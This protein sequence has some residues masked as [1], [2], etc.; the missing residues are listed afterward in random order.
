[1]WAPPEPPQH[2][3][4][5]RPAVLPWLLGPLGD[6]ALPLRLG[7]GLMS[8]S[9]SRRVT[10][11][12]A[13]QR[14]CYNVRVFIRRSCRHVF[15]PPPYGTRSSVPAP[16][17]RQA[18]TSEWAVTER[19]ASGT[20]VHTTQNETP[21]R[22]SVA[23]VHLTRW[24]RSER[25]GSAGFGVLRATCGV[26]GAPSHLLSALVRL[27]FFHCIRGALRTGSD[28]VISG[29]SAIVGGH[30]DLGHFIGQRLK[31]AVPP[32]LLPRRGPR[33]HHPRMSRLCPHVPRGP[34]RSSVWH[35]LGTAA[36]TQGPRSSMGACHAPAVFIRVRVRSLPWGPARGR[37]HL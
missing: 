23:G 20:R 34:E 9:T 10:F 28:Y 33:Q 25:R 8:S 22:V 35:P 18:L 21:P 27:L 24:A 19:G 36:E 17:T 29:K 32:S 14:L 5:P 13:R 1:M 37:Q 11:D 26:R 6:R 2:R 16:Y 31:S 15:H 30:R 7:L 4:L 3:A 12:A